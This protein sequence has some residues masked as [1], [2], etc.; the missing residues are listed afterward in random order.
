[1]AAHFTEPS[2]HHAVGHAAE[3]VS[4][5]RANRLASFNS[6]CRKGIPKVTGVLEVS[7]ER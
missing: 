4:L 3:G 6:P 1:M 2:G 7:G 5:S